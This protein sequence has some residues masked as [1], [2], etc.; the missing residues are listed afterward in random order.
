VQTWNRIHYGQRKQLESGYKIIDLARTGICHRGIW[1][2]VAQLGHR[3][4]RTHYLQISKK[5]MNARHIHT[6]ALSVN[7]ERQ[8]LSI[9][10]ASVRYECW[11][12]F[13]KFC[14][15]CCGKTRYG[16]RLCFRSDLRIRAFESSCQNPTKTILGL[17]NDVPLLSPW[18]IT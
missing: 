18:R 6:R 7:A 4:V 10:S 3:A 13:D 12:Y 1:C 17:T 8:R 15:L 14:L 16:E 5:E 2:R 9:S 11:G